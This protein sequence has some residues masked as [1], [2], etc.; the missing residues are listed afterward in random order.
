MFMETTCNPVQS[1]PIQATSVLHEMADHLVRSFM[2]KATGNKS[3]FVNDIPNNLQL[4]TDPQ[5]IASVLSGFLCAVVSYT[6]DSCIRLSAKIYDNIILVQIKDSGSFNTT[7]LESKVQKLQPL[8]ERLKGYVG[9]TS[10]RNSMTTLTF[11]F[12]NLPL[13]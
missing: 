10:R 2:V 11:G 8:A 4:S 1:K 7:A 12:P 3:F 6:K 13:Q 5:R 9:V